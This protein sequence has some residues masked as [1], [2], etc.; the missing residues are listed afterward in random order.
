VNE[1]L[2]S[3]ATTT[4]EPLIAARQ[5][6]AGYGRVTIVRDLDLEVLSG[7]VVAMVGPNGAGKSTTLR[8]LSGLQPP[9]GG[10][11][12]FGGSDGGAPLYRRA[13]GGLGYI[14]EQR[15]VL[16]SLTVLENLKVSRGNVALA[17][18]LFPDLEPHFGRK[19]GLLSG[20]Q[21]RMVALARILSRE[22]SVLLADELSLGLAP[23]IVDRLLR[24]VRAAADRGIGVILVEQHVRKALAIAD[25][26]VVLQR[27]RVQLAGRTSDFEGRFDEIRGAYFAGTA[28]EAEEADQNER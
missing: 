1:Q 6:S 16:M 9:L 20:G 18:Q 2:V 17:A 8:T 23:L 28:D 19:V 3:A 10:H 5:L 4:A 14:S 22:P 21:Q 7:E 15:P 27:G 24:E 12:F 26:I 11:V 13:R 25:R